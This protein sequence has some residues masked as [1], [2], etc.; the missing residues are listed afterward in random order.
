MILKK[1]FPVLLDAAQKM[2]K[3]FKQADKIKEKTVSKE[4]ILDN[5]RKKGEKGKKIEISPPKRGDE[6][7]TPEEFIK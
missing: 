2:H 1:S 7:L 5:L 4:D 3:M 6:N